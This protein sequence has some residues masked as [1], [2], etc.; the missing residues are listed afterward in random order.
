MREHVTVVLTGDG[1]DDVFLGYPFLKN[2]WIAQRGARMVPEFAAGTGRRL[3]PLIPFGPARN[4][5]G[6]ATAGLSAYARRRNL[7]YLEEHGI[8]GKRLEGVHLPLH[9]LTPSTASARRILFDV[10]GL[11]YKLHFLSEFMVKVDGA[12]M[13]HSL[14]AR[15]PFLDQKLWEFAAALPPSIRFHGGAL[16]AILREIVRRRVGRGVA[17]RRKQGFTVPVERWLAGR[18][19]GAL[20]V[21]SGRTQLEADGWIRP[22]SLE[23]PI[24]EARQRG[25]VPTQLWYLLI[26]EHWLQSNRGR[27]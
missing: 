20:D 5:V 15:S 8:T 24:R 23:N 10:L 27:I 22:G 11:H 21:L 6:Y 25:R 13:H 12:T 18:W 2:I 26:L 17:E 3:A 7:P 1:G 4:L 14:E 16:K 9:Q 19:S